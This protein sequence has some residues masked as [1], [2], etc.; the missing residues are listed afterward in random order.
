MGRYHNYAPC[1]LCGRMITTNAMAAHLKSCRR[2]PPND[3]I[4]QHYRDGVSIGRLSRIYNIRW[5][6]A[7]QWYRLAGYQGSPE[8]KGDVQRLYLREVDVRPNHLL[9]GRVFAP[10]L[11]ISGCPCQRI[12]ECRRRLA[13]DL[14]PL[15]QIPTRLDVALA[16]VHGRIGFDGN[17]P[18]WLP[19]LAEE[20]NGGTPA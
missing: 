18:D 1:P 16:Y 7:Q 13:L 5:Q 14:W 10:M 8:R 11:G 12:D 9:A 15:C 2:R 3:V 19:E 20:L 6:T 17:L 4:H